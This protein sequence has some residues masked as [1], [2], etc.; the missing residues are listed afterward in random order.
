MEL[1]N[2]E[3]FNILG[4]IADHHGDPLII[5]DDSFEIIF[6]NQ[7]A[8]SL[9]S[10]DDFN[11]TLDQI[12]DKNTV[13]EISDNAGIALNTFKNKTLDQLDLK[14]KSGSNLVSDISIELLN[15][16]ESINVVLIFSSSFKIDQDELIKKIKILSSK[17]LSL[18]KSINL[19]DL[20][21]EIKNL[22]PFTIVALKK[23]QILLDSCDLPVW[24]KDIDGKLICI[25]CELCKQVRYRK[26]F[27]IR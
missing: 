17:N 26:Y 9:F 8:V 15:L 5:L 3:W 13:N 12:F 10:I 11:I 27:C 14:L 22:A 7:T 21:S 20:I 18:I 25:K 4:K 24:I 23:I 19:K 6:S 2:K 16:D 1:K